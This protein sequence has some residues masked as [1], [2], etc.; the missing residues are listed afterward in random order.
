MVLYREGLMGL[1][2]IPGQLHSSPVNE[3]R[4]SW[5]RYNHPEATAGTPNPCL[6][7]ESQGLGEGHQEVRWEA[8]TPPRY[9]GGVGSRPWEVQKPPREQVKMLGFHPVELDSVSPE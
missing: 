8:Q 4:N 1:L 3:G 6:D 5:L 9:H 2:Q 7:S